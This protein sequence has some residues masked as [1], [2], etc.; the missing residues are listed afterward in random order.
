MS[1]RLN[2]RRARS[3]C[4]RPARL[5]P[6]YRRT[7]ASRESR[8]RSRQADPAARRRERR[9]S[10]RGSNAVANVVLECANQPNTLV[11]SAAISAVD[12]ILDSCAQGK[13]RNRHDER[14]QGDDPRGVAT[15][16]DAQPDRDRGVDRE[17]QKRQRHIDERAIDERVDRVEPVPHDRDPDRRN[18]R[19][20][21]H[22]EKCERLGASAAEP[23]AHHDVEREDEGD[24]R[25]TP[26]EPLHLQSLD[27]DRSAEAEDDREGAGEEAR[28]DADGERD[29][30]ARVDDELSER[31]TDDGVR[32]VF[33]R[34]RVRLR[35]EQL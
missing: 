4:G 18:E 33:V 24:Q 27:A 8:R 3:S 23:G 15:D 35:I 20:L 13:E 19:E 32:D 25:R 7:L 28:N 5:S 30:D 16:H 22:E 17:E 34:R 9:R 6:W 14:R 21:G 11:P 26:H 10:L 31:V 2:S 29:P 12:E 1:S